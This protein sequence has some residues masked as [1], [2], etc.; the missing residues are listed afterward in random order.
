MI[1]IVITTT[2]M[3]LSCCLVDITLVVGSSLGRF[4]MQRQ[5]NANQNSVRYI[6]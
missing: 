3:H 4:D 1:F 2:S 5:R 6:R